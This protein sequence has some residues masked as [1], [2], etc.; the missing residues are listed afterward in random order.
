MGVPPPLLSRNER[1]MGV[2]A[3]EMMAL[4][5]LLNHLTMLET[6]SLEDVPEVWLKRLWGEIQRK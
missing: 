5:C 3:L 1:G 6:E 4:R 2:D